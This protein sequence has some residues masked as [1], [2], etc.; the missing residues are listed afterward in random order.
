MVGPVTTIAAAAGLIPAGSFLFANRRRRGES[1]VDGAL[2]VVLGIA[3][4]GLA[5]TSGGA[6]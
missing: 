2:L 5:L 3:A 6:A 1:G 4:L